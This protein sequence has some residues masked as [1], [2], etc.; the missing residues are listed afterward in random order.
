MIKENPTFVKKLDFL[1]LR[2][3]HFRQLTPEL[4]PTSFL[5]SSFL[6]KKLEKH[7]ISFKIRCF[8]WLRRQDSNLRPPG[9]EPDELPTALLRDIQGALFSA[10]IFYHVH[11]RLSSIISCFCPTVFDL[12]FLCPIPAQRAVSA[13]PFSQFW[14]HNFC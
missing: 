12:T 8:L 5:Q 2:F 13:M 6:L 9:Y 4:T 3:W 11:L 7:R 14:K 1:G 10:C